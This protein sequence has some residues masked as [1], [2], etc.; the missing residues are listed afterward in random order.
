MLIDP[1]VATWKNV[2]FTDTNAT[3][4]GHK[5]GRGLEGLN[6]V[7][8]PAIRAF[9]RPGDEKGWKIPVQAEVLMP[10]QI[11]LDYVTKIAFVSNA[12]LQFAD[13][14]C[15]LQNHPPFVVQ[16]H[17]FTDIDISTSTARKWII[18][19]P[20]LLDLT[21][22]GPKFDQ[23][24]VNLSKKNIFSRVAEQDI[25]LLAQV[26]AKPGIRAKIH[27]HPIDKIEES[28]SFPRAE[29]Y[30]LQCSISVKE[31]PAGPCAVEFFLGG[32][33]WIRWGLVHFEMRER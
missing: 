22:A 7:N 4:N 24:M 6:L 21:L 28:E 12:S 9:P 26:K 32:I 16:E 13:A 3:R 1:Q 23:N 18:D 10:D 14:L 2:V 31:L 15:K 29:T 19:F 5:R 11:P 30:G 25:S 20:H 17:P 27:W 33:R 8:F